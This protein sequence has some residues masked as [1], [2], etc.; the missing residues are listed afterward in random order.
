MKFLRVN[1]IHQT[2]QSEDVLKRYSTLGGRA[3]N[4]IM[5]NNDI[6]ATT[7]PL[8]CNNKLVFA[9]EYFTGTS[10]I[11]TSRLSAGVKSPL[12]RCIKKSNVGG[13]VGFSLA[14]GSPL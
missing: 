5:V 12:T 11:N 6:P 13:T 7:D 1:M 10:L 3:L 9:P 8:G 4:S 14:K 2:V